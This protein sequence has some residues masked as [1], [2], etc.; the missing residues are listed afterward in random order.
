MQYVGNYSVYIHDIVVNGRI[1]TLSITFA[2]SRSHSLPSNSL[3]L[4]MYMEFFEY[5]Y[6]AETRYALRPTAPVDARSVYGSCHSRL[7]RAAQ[8][9]NHL[10]F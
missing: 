3:Q 9:Y 8:K 1:I 10:H 4:C 7:E 5:N 6:A 2:L